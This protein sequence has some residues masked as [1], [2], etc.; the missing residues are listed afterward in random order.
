MGR[1]ALHRWRPDDLVC[2]RLLI[3][4]VALGASRGGH[5][6]ELRA[7]SQ[8][9]RAKRPNVAALDCRL[10]RHLGRR[11]VLGR[12]RAV[13][14]RVHRTEFA[15][16]IFDF[17]RRPDHRREGGWV[18]RLRAAAVAH[19]A[20]DG[21]PALAHA[22][23]SGDLPASRCVPEPAAE[24]AT[25]TTTGRR[26][27]LRRSRHRVVRALPRR[28]Q[29]LPPARHPCA[30]PPDVRRVPRAARRAAC[31]AAVPAAV[32]AARGLALIAA[33]GPAAAAAIASAGSVP[34]SVRGPHR[35]RVVHVWRQPEPVPRGL[36][37]GQLPPHLWLLQ[38]SVS[39]V[40]ADASVAAFA[41]AAASA[42]AFVVALAALT[43]ATAAQR[44]HRRHRRLECRLGAAVASVRDLGGQCAVG[45]AE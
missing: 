5:S 44:V 43:L 35:R 32:A 23:R 17:V 3:G 18:P 25:H 2:V 42:A 21:L 9:A 36:L 4:G 1:G 38:L 19:R 29:P 34:T 40:T 8:H 13:Q 26:Q 15:R 6:G 28:A 7:P 16:P 39:A 14:R 31:A 10:A 30:V 27:L 41:V 12:R 11:H 37:H 22:E 24:P 33:A 45:R 20:A